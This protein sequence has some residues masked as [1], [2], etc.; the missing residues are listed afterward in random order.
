MKF[1]YIT[2]IS[3]LALSITIGLTTYYK[4][5]MDNAFYKRFASNSRFAHIINRF[6]RKIE[7]KPDYY[8]DVFH[9]MAFHSHFV[10]FVISLVLCIIDVTNGYVI[11]NYLGIKIMSL[12]EIILLLTPV[13]YDLV[14]K[15]IWN[16]IRKKNK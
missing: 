7:K 16:H 15:I 4:T 2:L 1:Y 5:T 9:E 10:I 11:S 3:L 14:L 12:I 8:L 6:I 13:L